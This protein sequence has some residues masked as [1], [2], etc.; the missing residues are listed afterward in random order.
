MLA[1]LNGR[2][3]LVIHA[4]CRAKAS[5][6][7]QPISPKSHKINDFLGHVAY[8][9]YR[10]Y[11]PIIGRWPSRDPIEERGGVNLYGFVFANPT[12][13]IDILG[14]DF[15]TWGDSDSN[16]W[17]PSF[18]EMAESTAHFV[19]GMGD[20]LSLGLT[21]KGREEIWG[22]DYT[23]PCRDAYKW[24]D[25]AGTALELAMGA[26]AL[27]AGAKQAVREAGKEFSHWIPS[28]YFRN[29]TKYFGE[30]S[31]LAK[32]LISKPSH[33]F[34]NSMFNGNMV[35]PLKHYKTDPFRFPKGWRDMGDRHRAWRRMIER[36][37]NSLQKTAAS[38][39]AASISGAVD[40]SCK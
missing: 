4:L 20:N 8:Y 17:L 33:A 34:K 27:K 36:I 25:K 39:T 21:R 29:P 6:Q 38:G 32:V 3:A 7:R 15:W 35:S 23:D 1:T 5:T 22:N 19:Q 26:G 10:Y 30:N 2:P 16:D 31:I 40:C 18:G 13:A 37:P 14:L 9:G 24:G 28:R 11:D 12:N